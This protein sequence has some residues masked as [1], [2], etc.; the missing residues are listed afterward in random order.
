MLFGLCPVKFLCHPHG[1][2]WWRWPRRKR[3]NGGRTP[4]HWISHKQIGKLLRENSK[5]KWAFCTVSAIPE[6][7]LQTVVKKLRKSFNHTASRNV[8]S[9]SGG[10]N[11]KRWGFY[12]KWKNGRS[13]NALSHE[14]LACCCADLVEANMEFACNKAWELHKN[15][16]KVKETYI[17]ACE[18]KR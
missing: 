7:N 5:L 14:Q 15:I 17:Q 2:T 1:G 9:K 16:Y 12:K 11:S 18:L 10:R 6:K 3:K 8:L 4:K 13:P